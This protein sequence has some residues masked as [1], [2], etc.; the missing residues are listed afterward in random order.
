MPGD[1]NYKGWNPQAVQKILQDIFGAKFRAPKGKAKA[2]VLAQILDEHLERLD[3]RYPNSRPGELL[4]KHYSQN[5]SLTILG[6]ERART[7]QRMGQIRQG[8]IRILRHP[9]S[10]LRASIY[11]V[12]D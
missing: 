5:M 7:R 11:R 3:S 4:Y 8:S 6:Y 1:N 12:L 9:R 10:A 2:K